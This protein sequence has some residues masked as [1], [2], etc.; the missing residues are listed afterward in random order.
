MGNN[1]RFSKKGFLLM[2]V[3]FVLTFYY[4]TFSIFIK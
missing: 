1:K 3:V 4:V 2:I